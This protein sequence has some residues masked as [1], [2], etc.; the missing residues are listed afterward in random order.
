MEQIKKHYPGC[1]RVSLGE[2]FG[3]IK[4]VGREW[5]AEIRASDSGDLLRFAGIWGTRKAAVE[6]VISTN[7]W[8]AKDSLV[9]QVCDITVNDQGSIILFTPK[10]DAC[11]EWIED[12]VQ[13][14]GWQWLGGGFGVDHSYADSLIDGL[15]AEGFEVQ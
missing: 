14:E 3:Q 5:H 1:Y 10:S 6:E 9:E 2:T 4:K 15:Q 12:N 8:R 7:S 13:L 11:K